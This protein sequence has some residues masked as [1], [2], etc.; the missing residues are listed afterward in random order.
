[1]S[2]TIGIVGGGQLGRMLTDAAHKLG[3]LVTVLD[4]TPNSPAGQIADKQIIGS[5]ADEEKIKELAKEVDYMTFEIESANAKA[6]EELTTSGY[7][8][9]PSSKTLTIIKDKLRQKEFLRDAGIPVGEFVE[10]HSSVISNEKRDPLKTEISHSVRNDKVMNE[11]KNIGEKFGYPMLL[12]ARVDA[13]DGRGNALIR[14]ENEID[15]AM[16]KL[17]NK[18]LYIEQFVPFIKEISVMVARSLSGDIMTYPVSENIHKNNILQTAIM[19]ARISEKAAQNAR[20]VATNVMQ[21]LGGAGVFGIEMFLMEDDTV[22]VNE[23][24]PR[25]HNSGH[26]TIEACQTSQF[27]QH[28]RAITGMELGPTDMKVPAA[29]MINILGKE[30]RVAKPTGVEK[31]TEIQGVAVHLYGKA[32]SRKERKMGHIT[33]VGNT[34][35]EALEKAEKA[36]NYISI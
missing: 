27:E 3:F 24:A 12:K 5:F 34:V 33:A 18:Q 11:I 22:F 6:L 13:Y 30:D 17:H 32:E 31:A 36:R 25:V 8:V 21:H 2:K 10:I 15:D 23:I 19:P 14:S 29:V 7:P 26:H 16:Q 28:I 1:M 4:P 35:E 20:E 9:N